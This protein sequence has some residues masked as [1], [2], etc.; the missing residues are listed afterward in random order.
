MPIFAQGSRAGRLAAGAADAFL[1]LM[2]PTRCVLCDQPGDLLCDDCR[3]TLPWIEQRLACPVCGAPF[4]QLICTECEKDWEM[5]ACVAAMG[6]H[7][8]PARM[9]SCLKDAHELRL[10]P[11]IAQALLTALE[12]AAAWP[13]A[14]GRPRVDLAALDAVCFVPA[15]AEAYRRRGFD[16]MELVSQNLAPALGLPLYDVLVRAASKDQRELGRAQREE[17]LAGTM[18]TV[19][20]VSGLDLLLVD[21]VVTTGSSVRE[22]ARTLLAAGA[23]SVTACA[24]AR[25]W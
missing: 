13:A 23:A 6:F 14:D 4:G 7:G 20:D 25:V 21:D 15:T 3:A 8:A 5:R 10:A 18:R 12:E 16:H 9:V 24:L 17:N 1:E 11:V 2:W 19:Q 22:A